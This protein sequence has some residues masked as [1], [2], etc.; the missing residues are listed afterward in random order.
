MS[1]VAK[2]VTNRMK[3]KTGSVTDYAKNV[4]NAIMGRTTAPETIY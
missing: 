4:A 2:N 3:E 1:D